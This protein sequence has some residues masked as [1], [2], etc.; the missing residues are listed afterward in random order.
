MDKVLHIFDMDDV[1]TVTPVFADF[2]EV[3]EGS[4][5]VTSKADEKIKEYFIKVRAAFWD[6]LAK[7][8]R[9]IK[10]GDFVVV[11]NAKDDKPFTSEVLNYFPEN[12]WGR[13]FSIRD[14]KL[15]LEPYPGFHSNPETIGT[16]VNDEAFGIYK[17][18]ENK[19]ILTGRNK[20]MRPLI[21]KNLKKLGVEYPNYGFIMYPGGIKIK[22]FKTQVIFDAI[23]KNGWEE[24]HFYEDREDWLHHA[25]GAVKEKYPNL[26]FVTHHISNIDDQRKMA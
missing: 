13:I 25:E 16:K 26:K 11:V 23:D 8:I 3:K 1:L 6:R 10:S 24:V 21:E 20:T 7:Q 2:M 12:K 15:I 14:G 5:I 17:N 19:M 9:F 18:V 22:D 4:Y